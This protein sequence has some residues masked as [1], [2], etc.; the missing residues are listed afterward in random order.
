MF[1]STEESNGM[2]YILFHGLSFKH[3]RSTT[4][5]Y[6]CLRITDALG[7]WTIPYAPLLTDPYPTPTALQSVSLPGVQ[8]LSDHAYRVVNE[9]AADQVLS[10]FAAGHYDVY[11]CLVCGRQFASLFDARLHVHSHW[12]TVHP[13]ECVQWYAVLSWSDAL[14]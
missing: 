3:A 7:V 10:R 6:Q 5:P 11:V 14:H 4:R 1:P 12:D 8:T 9:D 2:R 13:L